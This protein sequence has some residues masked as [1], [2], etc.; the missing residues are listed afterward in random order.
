MCVSTTFRAVAPGRL[1]GAGPVPPVLS[2]FPVQPDTEA[3][4]LSRVALFQVHWTLTADSGET[5][6]ITL[7]ESTSTRFVLTDSHPIV[8]GISVPVCT[9]NSM[10]G[11][12]G[13]GTTTV[14]CPKG[15]GMTVLAGD[16]NDQV[17]V[18]SSMAYPVVLRG[19]SGGDRLTGGAANDVIDGGPGADPVLSGQGG[20]DT[21]NGGTGADGS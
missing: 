4:T 10:C 11:C 13:F 16:Q 17:S 20:N 7:G 19:E 18:A 6:T 2:A 21:I 1:L 3:S 9:L 14:T 8:L 15:D 5:N 12:D